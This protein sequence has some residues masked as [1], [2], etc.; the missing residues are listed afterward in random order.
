MK[1]W[2]W[3]EVREKIRRDLDLESE[4]FVR[5]EE[6][7]GYA[8]EAI[9]EAEA[10]IHALYEDYFLTSA[11]VSLVAGQDEYDLPSDIYAHKIRRIVYNNGASV[12]TVTR[13]GDWKKFETKSIADNFSTSDLYQFFIKNPSAGSPKFVL[14]P[15]ARETVADVLEIWYLRNANRLVDDT[16]VIDIPEFINYIFQK[17]TCL[18]YEK[19]GHPNLD[20]AEMKLAEERNRM[21][22]V[23]AQMVPDAENEIEMDTSFYEEMN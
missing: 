12:Y 16:D 17:I 11:T 7:L 22:G 15:K 21:L 9:D 3:S 10:E 5:P 23:L 14:V 6:L 19:E 1:F 18:V 13:I 20:R 4:V 8:N 2:T